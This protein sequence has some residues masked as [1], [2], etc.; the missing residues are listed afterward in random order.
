MWQIVGKGGGPGGK[1][2]GDTQGN[3]FPAK[4]AACSKEM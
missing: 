4:G 1:D 3:A 2:G